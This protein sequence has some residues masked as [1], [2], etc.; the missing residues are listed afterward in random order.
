MPVLYSRFLA[1]LLAK[2]KHDGLCFNLQQDPPL[3]KPQTSSGSPVYRQ[4]GQATQQAPPSRGTILIAFVT[5]GNPMTVQD[6]TPFGNDE[7]RA[8]D[9][10]NCVQ[11]D[12]DK[13]RTNS[14]D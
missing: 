2:H 14:P 8:D 6:V 13:Q 5:G 11:G 7:W 10:L 9:S 4:Q 12:C 1:S 3:Q